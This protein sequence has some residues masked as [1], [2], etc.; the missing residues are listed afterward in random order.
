MHTNP[1]NNRFAPGTFAPAPRRAPRHKMMAAQGRMETILFLRHGEQQL[2]SVVIPLAMLLIVGRIPLLGE[3]TGV[4]EIFPMMLAIATTSSGFTGQAIA[5]AFDRRY[6]ALKRTGASGVPAETI[7]AGKVIAVAV[8]AVL[9]TFLLGG[10]ALALGWRVDLTGIALGAITLLAGV[11]AFSALGLLMGGTLGAEVVL[12]L[13][14]LI[15]VVL[16]GLVGWVV[17]SQGL[18][19][20]G[21]YTAIPSVALAAGLTLSFEGIVPW[22]EILVLLGWSVAAVAAA[23]RW[24]RFSS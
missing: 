9:Q 19:D 1:E 23:T 10:A 4:D 14:N 3:D 5:L 13:A 12:A 24:F 21:W 17:Y 11:A 18:T 22:T 15:W 6:G 16:I 2:L 7:I 8:M 20:A